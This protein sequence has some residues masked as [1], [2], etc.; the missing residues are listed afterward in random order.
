[1]RTVSTFKLGDK[2]K[3]IRYGVQG[4]RVDPEGFHHIRPTEG[5]VV[6]VHPRRYYYGVRFM[7]KYTECFFPD[8]MVKIS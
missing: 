6:Y 2:V 8:R 3:V 5:E 4:K 7:G 1:M